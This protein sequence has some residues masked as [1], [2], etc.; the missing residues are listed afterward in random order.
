MKHDR[1][2]V[3]MVNQWV[4]CW[5]GW[6]LLLAWCVLTWKR[7]FYHIQ[8][9][10]CFVASSGMEELDWV[11]PL[12]VHLSY[13]KIREIFSRK[14]KVLFHHFYVG[15][16]VGGQNLPILLDFDVIWKIFHLPYKQVQDPINKSNVIWETY[17]Q[18]TAR[19]SVCDWIWLRVS[20][21]A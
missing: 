19:L 13:I 17:G 2:Y 18:N 8:W 1:F 20:L 7:P 15:L 3:Y 6:T 21:I 10:V 11:I 14:V 5:L 9:H 16:I 12:H 4:D